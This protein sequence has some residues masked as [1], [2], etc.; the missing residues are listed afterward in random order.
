M[1]NDYGT[2]ARAFANRQGG[3]QR[4]MP[5]QQPQRQ[6]LAVQPAGMLPRNGGIMPP[7][8]QQTGPA[9]QMNRTVSLS[10]PNRMRRPM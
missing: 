2:M 9:Q 4:Q 5:Q 8:M 7:H 10:P 1:N 3:M 6:M